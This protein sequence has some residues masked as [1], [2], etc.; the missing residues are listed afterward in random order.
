MSNQMIASRFATVLASFK[1]HFPFGT[2]LGGDWN[3]WN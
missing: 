3:I 1:E 2:G